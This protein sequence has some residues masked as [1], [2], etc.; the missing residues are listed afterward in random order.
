MKKF[1]DRNSLYLAWLIAAIS[2]VGSLYFSEIAGYT[3][4]NLCWYQRIVMYPLVVVIAVG[5]IKK[6]RL[7]PYFVLPL[8]LIG[9][10]IAL[11]H[12]LLSIGVVA[13]PITPCGLGVSCTEKYI[14]WLGFISIPLLSLAAFVTIFA[15]MVYLIK[16]HE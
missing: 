11:Y 5:I 1:L 12:E 6:D 4:C 2:T 8:S 13:E 16:R 10:V 9:G 15:L 3:P 14:N 7:T